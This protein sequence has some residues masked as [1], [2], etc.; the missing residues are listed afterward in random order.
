MQ[1]TY[2]NY[3]L[4]SIISYLGLLVGLIIIKLAP[5]EHKPGKKYFILLR[6]ILF[7]LILVPLLLSYKVHF[8]LLIVVLLFVIVLIISNKI[9]L[10]ISERVYFILG[11]V[12]Y[13]SSKIFNLFIIESVLIFLYG[14]P[15]ASLLLKKRN[16]F[17]IFIRNLW[18]FVPVV[19]LYFI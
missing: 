12:F 15:N 10:N 1:I 16:Y 4:A 13:L 9:N 11:I 6:K 8:I 2:L 17:D 5:E 14:I 18:F 7:F 19:L 3:F